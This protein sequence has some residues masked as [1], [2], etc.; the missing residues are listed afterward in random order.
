MI[1][2]KLISQ[3]QDFAYDQSNQFGAPAQPIID[4]SN[5]IGQRLALE[6]K[7]NK[8]VVLLGTLLMD[9][10][11]GQAINQSRQP[12][13][14]EMSAEKAAE[15]LQNDPDITT[16]ELENVLACVRQHHGV[17]KFY[18][19][20][21]EVCC[22]A[23]C[24]RFASAKGF[25]LSIRYLRGMEFGDLMQLVRSKVEEK[26]SALSLDMCRQELRSDYTV[27]KTLLDSIGS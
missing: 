20:E 2:P 6:L 15:L 16:S 24:Y 18:S 26:W 8:E 23:D 14:V 1:T 12:E 13:H 4:L 5:D 19:L 3:I 25:L 10:M 27:I 17:K 22:N 9:C 11:L 7:A 21:S